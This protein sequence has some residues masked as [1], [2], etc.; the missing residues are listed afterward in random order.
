MA[1]SGDVGGVEDL[2][3]VEKSFFGL[4]RDEIVYPT[5]YRPFGR[6][7]SFL[8]DNRHLFTLIGVFGAVAVYLRT[9]GAELSEP[10]GDLGDFAVFSGL[11]LVALLSLIVV[12]KLWIEVRRVGIWEGLFLYI[13]ASLF[14]PLMGVITG[15][16]SVFSE[17]LAAYSLITIYVLAMGTGVT[18]AIGVGWVA[19]KAED[20]WSVDVPIIQTVVYLASTL[21]FSS[22]LTFTRLSNQTDFDT[23]TLDVMTISDW[24]YLYL[25]FSLAVCSMLLILLFVLSLVVTVVMVIGYAGLRIW[26]QMNE[27]WG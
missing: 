9:V 23:E 4:I 21:V 24:I 10:L 14:L 19:A 6:L 1:D 12:I 2:E 26:S 3:L 13:F 22:V 7:D 8:W 11:A 16:I 25:A 18:L 5:L 15:I 27:L 17:V 20:I